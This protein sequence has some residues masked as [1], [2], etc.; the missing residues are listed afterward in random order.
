MKIDSPYTANVAIIGAGPA[1]LSLAK[2]LHEKGVSYVVLEKEADIGGK[3]FSFIYQDRVIE[4]GTCYTT[5]N[6]HQTKKWMKELDIELVHLGRALFDGRSPVKYA[7]QGSGAPLYTQALR[8]SWLTQRLKKGILNS[9]PAAIR[10]GSLSTKDWLEKNGLHKIALAMHRLQTVQGYGYI[11]DTS[12]AQTLLWC[13]LRYVLTGLLNAIHM[14]KEGWSEFWRRLAAPLNVVTDTRITNIERDQQGVDIT[15]NGASER[16]KYLVSTIPIDDFG[17]ICPLSDTERQIC[18]ATKWRKYTTS[19]ISSPDWFSDVRV[20]A[21]SSAMIDESKMGELFGGRLEG[22]S[23]E[24]GGHLYVTGQY[25]YG[26]SN[27]ELQELLYH[28]A[29]AHGFT[30]GSI[31]KQCTYKYGPIYDKEAIS[32]GLLDK[33]R[34]VQGQNNTYHGGAG[35]SHELISSVVSHSKSLARLIPDNCSSVAMQSAK[36]KR[37]LTKAS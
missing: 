27:S 8:Y 25:H 10:E 15:A 32:N 6:H 30:I 35:F 18:D 12:I 21:F 24:M 13:D 20:Q 11:D 31:I 33:L 29:R 7:K 14:P 17:K 1:G 2:F 19:L 26:L 34:S 36:E 3:S 37:T 5:L 9:D 22:K 16:Y 4:L 28:G 23:E